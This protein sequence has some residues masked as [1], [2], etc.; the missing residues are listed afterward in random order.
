[1]EA[2]P[3]LVKGL[4]FEEYSNLQPDL[5][6]F[7]HKLFSQLLE[8][9]SSDESYDSALKFCKEK[10]KPFNDEDFPPNQC[11]LLFPSITIQSKENSIKWS[12]Y[13][14]KRISELPNYS[15]PVI[16]NGNISPIFIKQGALSDCYFLSALAIV[17]ERPNLVEALFSQG[18]EINEF[19]IH[20]VKLYQNG[21]AKSVLID[22]YFPC[23][24]EGNLAFS[25]SKENELWAMLLE[26]AWA[27]LHSSYNLIDSQNEQIDTILQS[28]TGSQCMV[29]N[30]DDE[31]LWSYLIEGKEKG[32]L[33]SASAANTKASKELL[34]EMGLAGSFAYAIVDVME[35]E[36]KDGVE[37]II[38]L[39]NPWGTKE[40]AGEWSESSNIWTEDLRFRLNCQGSKSEE[41]K[42]FWMSY[43]DF[44]HYFSRVQICK[45]GPDCVHSS[46][47]LQ[48]NSHPSCVRVV[49]N[50]PGI[51]LLSVHQP[52]R[53]YYE[54][55]D[56]EYSLIRLIIA[57][58]NDEKKQGKD[59]FC[60]IKG[61]MKLD[62][63]LSEDHTFE[64]GEYLIYIEAEKKK[65]AEKP[66]SLIEEIENDIPIT[67][68]LYAPKDIILKG[69]EYAQHPNFLEDVYSSCAVLNG[70]HF[71]YSADGAP[72]CSKYSG[73]R[74]EGYGYTY[75]ENGS[76]DATIKESVTYTMFDGLEL[77]PPYKGTSYEVLVPPKTSTIVLLKQTS[78]TGYNLSFSYTSNIIFTTEAMQK[79]IKQYG[80]KATRKD[81]HVN[82]DID[83]CVYTLKHGGGICYLYEN[84]T[85]NLVLEERVVLKTNGLYIV[86]EE[87]NVITI[88]IGPGESKFIE[89]RAITSNWNIQ[90]S[91]SY[92]ISPARKNTEDE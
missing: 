53:E 41:E 74:R 33:M 40:W 45:V 21:I 31:N 1:M 51:G 67:L 22:N 77:V 92:G 3:L 91:V 83:I 81:P 72:Q 34:E 26:K 9:T 5:G 20:A 13:Q 32:W 29:V 35:I 39:R 85:K 89:L 60:Y 87:G 50:K 90:T 48:L 63:E 30:H 65:C 80:T 44:C 54:Y 61:N 55:K 43:A 23:T 58:V 76:E 14:W 47:R 68:S 38:R 25:H 70:E 64:E 75:F 46:L 52:D 84:L 82:G 8:L 88:K 19:G 57:Q 24:K 62:R 42:V 15:K 86:G 69:D 17:A 2:L 18:S 4:N 36:M 7:G 16:F 73:M 49:V 56:Y 28:L 12:N 10:G 6:E 59:K 78:V 71:T 66:K 27:K 37:Q 11:S 79:R